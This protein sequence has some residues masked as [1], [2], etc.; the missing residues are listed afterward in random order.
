M[1][2]R[3]QVLQHAIKE[4]VNIYMH[5]KPTLPDSAIDGLTVMAYEQNILCP[6]TDICATLPF[7]CSTRMG[8]VHG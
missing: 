3:L 4:D 8:K 6:T 5:I 7:T 1:K 2:R